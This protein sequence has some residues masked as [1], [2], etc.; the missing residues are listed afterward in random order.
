MALRATAPAARIQQH[1]KGYNKGNLN[2]EQDWND[3]QRRK[4]G[5]Q[6]NP[7]RRNNAA[8]YD[9]CLQNARSQVGLNYFFADTGH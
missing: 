1:A 7:G 2:Q 6:H 3:A 4:G 9:Q 8:G 5:C